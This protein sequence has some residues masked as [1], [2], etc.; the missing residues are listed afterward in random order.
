MLTVVD[1]G[2]ISDATIIASIRLVHYPIDIFNSVSLLYTSKSDF[3]YYVSTSI[4]IFN[5]LCVYKIWISKVYSLA[6][7]FTYV[8]CMYMYTLL[9]SFVNALAKQWWN[10]QLH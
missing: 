10:Q 3:L 7:A 6:I 5:Q 2:V 8:Y 1:V 9:L 4:N